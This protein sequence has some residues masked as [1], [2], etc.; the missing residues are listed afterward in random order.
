M[1]LL[2]LVDYLKSKSITALLTAVDAGDLKDVEHAGVSSLMDA[3][4]LLQNIE[5]S[6]ERNRGLYVIKARGMA[7]SNQ[8]REFLLSDQG[9]VLRDAYLGRGEVLTGSARVARRRWTGN[10]RSNGNLRLRSAS[11]TSS[12]GVGRSRRRL[13]VCRPNWR[14]GHRK[15][16]VGARQSRRL[17]GGRDGADG[18]GRFARERDMTPVAEPEGVVWTLRLY[19]AG[20]T[21]KS[22]TALANLKRLCEEQLAERYKLEIVDL[23]E[24]PERAK[25]DQIVAIPT[26]VRQL[27]PPLKRIIGDLSNTERVIVGLELDPSDS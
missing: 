11:A 15:G 18:D 23:L 13:P 6:G 12:A 17:P 10:R 25:A 21:P 7:H 14:S 2:R 22:V 19:I 26:L 9:V 1:M 27:P 3:W 16:P 24:H 5:G 8:I 20:H 4:L